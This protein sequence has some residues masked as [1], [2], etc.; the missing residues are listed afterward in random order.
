AQFV[1]LFVS[2]PHPAFRGDYGRALLLVVFG[3]AT[4]A[5]LV[6]L[7]NASWIRVTEV[8]VA[9]PG[10]PKTWKSRT[11]VLASD[12]H[13]GPV[14]GFCFARRVAKLASRLK[15]DVVLLTGDFYDGT[16]VD[17]VKMASAWKDFAATFG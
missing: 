6:A 8:S 13:L 9:L 1:G 2:T 12:L 5:A 10:L 4:L 17:V 7:V 15:P 11:A 14:R 3:A 16:A